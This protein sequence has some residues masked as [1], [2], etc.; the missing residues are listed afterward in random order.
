MP[1]GTRSLFISSACILF[2]SGKF[3][4]PGGSTNCLLEV[5]VVN[6]R[7]VVDKFLVLEVFR[8]IRDLSLSAIHASKDKSRIPLRPS[9]KV[10][11][12][13]DEELEER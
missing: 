6:S 5:S 8:G 11:I 9:V 12:T 7:G 4:L 3:L 10:T 13:S 2:K 1:E